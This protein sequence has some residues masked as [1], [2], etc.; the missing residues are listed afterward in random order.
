MHRKVSSIRWFRK[1]TQIPAFWL[2]VGVI[3]IASVL[4]R[5]Q[6][7]LESLGDSIGSIEEWAKENLDASV[8]GQLRMLCHL[9]ALVIGERAAQIGIKALQD[10][11]KACRGRLWAVPRLAV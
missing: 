9:P 1:W 3:S 5:A 2:G 11:A 6:P 4:A 7:S 8:S 10:R